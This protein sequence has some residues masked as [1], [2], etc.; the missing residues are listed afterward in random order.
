[1]EVGAITHE[2]LD[3]YK[4][5][6]SAIFLNLMEAQVERMDELDDIGNFIKG[7]RYL[8][9]TKEARIEP[10]RA[11]NNGFEAAESKSAIGFRK[12]GFVY[13][14]N[15]VAY[16]SVVSHFRCFGKEFPASET[17]LRKR[18]NDNGHLISKSPKHV[19]HRL[20]VN[21]ER[22][23]CIVFTEETFNKLLGGKRDDYEDT[24]ELPHDRLMRGNANNSLGRGD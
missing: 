4:K 1:L 16:Q 15:N 23:Q 10:I 18:F 17:T 9:D 2:Q 14:K 3:S 20:T 22:Y 6:S 12:S 11:K 24:S 7:I 5:E 19:I 21:G 8:L 13:L